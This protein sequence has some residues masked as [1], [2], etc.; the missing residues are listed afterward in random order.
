MEGGVF[1][2]ELAE[3]GESRRLATEEVWPRGTI[4]KVMVTLSSLEPTEQPPECGRLVLSAPRCGL[5]LGPTRW[6]GVGA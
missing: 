4:P 1:L 5:L 3:A 2:L 6:A